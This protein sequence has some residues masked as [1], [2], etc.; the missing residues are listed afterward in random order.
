MTIV[1]IGASFTAFTSPLLYVIWL[2]R[3]KGGIFVII[4]SLMRSEDH[5]VAMKRLHT[6]FLLFPVLDYLPNWTLD[7]AKTGIR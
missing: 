2:T 1:A 7:A 6:L 3:P 5:T 4:L